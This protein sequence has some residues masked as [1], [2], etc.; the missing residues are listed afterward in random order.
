MVKVI[1]LHPSMVRDFVN[2]ASKCDFDIDVASNNRYYIDAKS[3]LGV[4]ALD[5]SKPLT[6]S[7]DGYNAEF[8]AFLVKTVQAC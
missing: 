3:I 2:A 5:L 8:E 4:L 6:V 1:S 7:Y